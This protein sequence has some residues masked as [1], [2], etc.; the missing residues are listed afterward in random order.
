MMRIGLTVVLLLAL[1]GCIDSSQQEIDQLKSKVE[2]QQDTIERL[3][4]EESDQ[5]KAREERITELESQ[6]EQLE[7]GAWFHQRRAAV[8]KACN[9]AVPM[10]PPGWTESGR[11]SLARGYTGTPSLLFWLIVGL[12]LI[13]FTLP[14]GLLGAAYLYWAKPVADQIKDAR[15]QLREVNQERD[16]KAKELEAMEAELG[17]KQEELRD[18]GNQLSLVKLERDEVQSEIEQL[19]KKQQMLRGFD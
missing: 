8:A 9:W 10:C 19:E 3:K 4:S 13:I 18:F 15:A 1:T 17:A 7:S 11:E 2:T 16:R 5:V 6:I 14:V 12:K